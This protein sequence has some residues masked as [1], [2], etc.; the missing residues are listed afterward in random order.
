MLRS[1]VSFKALMQLLGH[2]SPEM[3]LRYLEITQPDL[4]REY[5]LALTNPRHL[6]P[7]PR[8]RSISH[9]PTADLSSLLNAIHA[10]QQILEMFRRAL[11]DGEQRRLLA[12]IGNRLIKISA[13]LRNGATGE[14]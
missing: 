11:P 1:G 9:S 3:T 2:S 7:T 5:H 14:K 10:V 13:Q 4:Q 12:R 6:V 8:V